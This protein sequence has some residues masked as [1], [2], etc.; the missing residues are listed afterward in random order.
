MAGGCSTRMKSDAEKLLLEINGKA[1]AVHTVKIL[2]DSGLF[3][4]VLCATSA[5]APKT[6][7]V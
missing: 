2:S 5:N 6:A 4:H 3:E 1:M 7:K